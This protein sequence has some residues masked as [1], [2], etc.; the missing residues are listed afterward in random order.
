MGLAE[1]AELAVRISLKDNASAGIRG[2]QRNLSG[3]SG[4]VGRVGRG[5]GQIGTGL[6]R[7]GLLAGGAAVTGL[8]AVA[9]A[10]INFEDAFAGVRKTVN[11][12]DLKAVGL[13]FDKLATSFRNMATEIPIAATD[14][15]RIGETAGA[16]GIKAQDIQAF[17]KT[18][19][20]LGETTNLSTDAAAEALGKVG[21]ILHLTGRDFEAFAD[22]LVNLGN[23]GASTESE[24]IEVT[25]RFAAVGR[26][27]G[28]STD[29]ILALSSAAT[30]LGA[31]PEAAGSALSRIFAN[32]TTE[33]ADGSAKGKEFAKITGDSLDEL[34]KRLNKGDAL[35]ILQ[36]T[37]KGIAGLSRTEAASVL[38]ALGISN[39]RDRDAILKMAQNLD[40]VNDQLEIAKNSEGALWKEAEK[41]FATTASKIQLVKNN[42]IETGIAMG[43]EMLPAIGRALDK[44]IGVLKDPKTKA[45]A[46]QLG[47]DIGK[48][49]DDIDWNKVK[50]GAIALKDAMKGALDFALLLLRAI[51]TLPN[52]L[53]AAGLG[54]LALNKLSGG[55]IGAGVSNVVGGLAETITRGLGSQ[56]PG[57]G[58]LFAQPVF[59]TN[60]PIGGLGGAG[61]AGAAGAGKGSGVLGTLGKVFGVLAVAEIASEFHDEISGFGTELH[62]ALGIPDVG[63][64]PSDLEWPWGPKNAPT[65]AQFDPAPVVGGARGVQ[66]KGAAPSSSK[67]IK[68]FGSDHNRPLK[69]YGKVEDQR[70]AVQ[71]SKIADNTAKTGTKITIADDRLEAIKAHTA[72]QIP[73][74]NAI[75]QS[76]RDRGIAMANKIDT[77][78]TA[79]KAI[80]PAQQSVK[81][82]VTAIAT[83]NSITKSVRQSALY[84]AN[85]LSAVNK[86][87]N[88]G[89]T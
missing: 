17:T 75:T 54:F 24:I 58:K 8:A 30:S 22:T 44:V 48:F 60:W 18:V 77:V 85:H 21:T 63:F 86:G 51:D 39:V 40:F 81:L 74:L 34:R 4:S 35:G 59:V 64:K 53:K 80:P 16:L 47:K 70:G 31:E 11:E 12:S 2:L 83:A 20:L 6:A 89:W 25:K 67:D 71:W 45:S 43:N 66:P 57:V 32:M 38:K 5:F 73:K 37:L 42:L 87:N 28:L 65:W 82:T 52:E 61:A 15:A 13:D 56:L 36:E 50:D 72:S 14:L 10:A 78:R 49:I 69:I 84:T 33:I 26:Q 7:A 79:V 76:V 68:T 41:R 62:R 3:L 19:A 23:Q 29:Q 88:I 46:V 27:A 9:K 55:L 1:T